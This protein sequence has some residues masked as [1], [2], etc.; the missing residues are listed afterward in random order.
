MDAF[1]EAPCASHKARAICA[2]SSMESSVNK[3]QTASAMAPA[4]RASSKAASS[5]VPPQTSTSRFGDTSRR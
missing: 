3:S 2:E 4:A 5:K 1:K